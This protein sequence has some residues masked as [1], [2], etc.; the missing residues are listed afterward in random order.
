MSDNTRR[1][2]SER[3]ALE[4]QILGLTQRIAEYEER[5]RILGEDNRKLSSVNEKRIA[6]ID[7]WQHRYENLE[8]QR[9]NELETLR[10]EAD[11]R[12]QQ[13]VVNPSYF[14]KHIEYLCRT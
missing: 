7:E 1:F 6:E 3:K 4:G 9:V 5:L 10:R 12:L 14:N 13:E 2:A 8:R 11:H